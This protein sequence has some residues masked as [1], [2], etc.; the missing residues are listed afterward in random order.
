MKRSV[1]LLLGLVALAFKGFSQTSPEN[2]GRRGGFLSKMEFGLTAGG[3]AS[4]F[5]NANFPTDPLPGF[6]GGL[7][8]AY[9]FT[10][11]FIVQE[12]FLYTMQ[13][14]KVK[15]GL[16]G[17]RD[18]KLSYAAIPILLKYRTSSGFFVEAGPQ[19]GFK[20]K[21]DIGGV[22]DAKFFKKI[23]FGMIGGIG[24]KSNIGLGIDARYVYG[25][26]KVQEIPSTVLGDFKNNS[27]QASIF[28]VF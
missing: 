14:A 1:F 12:E 22:T 11:N 17:T 20:I 9:K 28:Y 7:T 19:A 4:N 24:Y 10:E 21:E 13:G 5:T 3:N 25:L 23:D 8:V 15:G 6:Q 16:L 27:I 26:Q 18:V 2:L